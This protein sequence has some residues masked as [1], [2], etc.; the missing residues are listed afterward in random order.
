MLSS[1]WYFRKGYNYDGERR[2]EE[3]PYE[4]FSSCVEKLR[5]HSNWTKVKQNVS[6]MEGWGCLAARE[7]KTLRI[8]VGTLSRM[9]LLSQ[10]S[11][12]LNQSFI[13][14]FIAVNDLDF[15]RSH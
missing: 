4:V 14:C 11:S 12:S 13:F 2:I 1:S 8:T 5:C 3:R 7:Q 10:N 15:E 6:K 9:K